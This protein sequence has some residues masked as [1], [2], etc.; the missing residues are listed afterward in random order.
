MLHMVHV[1]LPL[2]RRYNLLEGSI[3]QRPGLYK[4]YFLGLICSLPGQDDFHWVET[5]GP[6]L[7][8]DP[9]VRGGVAGVPLGL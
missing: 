6:A 2:S 4:L 1:F 3:P 8:G 9:M 5:L 7:Q